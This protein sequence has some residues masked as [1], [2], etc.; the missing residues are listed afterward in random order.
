MN[1]LS[2]LHRRLLFP[3]AIGF[4]LF[5]A[6]IFGYLL[7]RVQERMIEQKQRETV[8]K[9]QLVLGLLDELNRR[10]EMGTLTLSQAQSIALDEIRGIRYGRDH[11]NYFWVLDYNCQLLI[12][13]YHRDLVSRSNVKDFVN[14]EGRYIFAEFVELAKSEGAGFIQ[15]RFPEYDESVSDLKTSYVAAF[16]G[17]E[18]V[19]GT[20]FF[21][22]E[23][24]RDIESFIIR[25]TTACGGIALVVLILY[26]YLYYQMY[27]IAHRSKRAEAEAEQF[28]RRFGMVFE[29]TH[30]LMGMISP[31]GQV[32]RINQTALRMIGLPEESVKNRLFWETPWWSYAPEVQEECRRAVERA[33]AGETVQFETVH[34]TVEGRKA[35]VLV[36]FTPLLNTEGAVECILAQGVDLTDL[37]QAE[38]QLR[39]QEARYR[40]LVENARSLILRLDA[41][42]RI[43]FINEFALELLG[44]PEGELLG[45]SPVETFILPTDEADRD[46]YTPFRKMLLAGEDYQGLVTLCVSVDG[47]KYWISWS[48]RALRDDED[49]LTG[50]NLLV[51]VDVT[52]QRLAYEERSQLVA[53]VETLEEVVLV[54]DTVGNVVYANPALER[55][56]GLEPSAW[57]GKPLTS[58]LEQLRAGQFIEQL[59]QVT[60]THRR[61]WQERVMLHHSEGQI[62][63]VEVTARLVRGRSH[64]WVY[65]LRDVTREV[66]EAER[67]RQSQKMEAMGTLA[68]GIAH[69]F[70]NILNAITGNAELLLDEPVITPSGRACVDEILTAS[71]RASD[72]VRQI[73]TYSRQKPGELKPLSIGPLVKEALKLVKISLPPEVTLH[74]DIAPNLP[75]VMGD[76]TQIH[77]VVL[78]LCTNAI[79]AMEETQGGL[80]GVSLSLARFENS[81]LIDRDQDIQTGTYVCL[82]ISDT[83]CGIPEHIRDRIFDPFFTTKPEGKGTGMG[84]AIVQGV[85]SS[86]GGIIRLFSEPSWGTTFRLYFPAL[87]SPK[88]QQTSSDKTAESEP[89][90]PRP[91]V[92]GSGEKIL[93]VDDDRAVL[94]AM[95]LQ[96]RKLG[97][98]P[99]AMPGPREALAAFEAD[100]QTY[101]MIITDSNM[102]GMSGITMMERIR[103]IRPD[104]PAILV[105]GLSTNQVDESALRAGIRRT[106]TKPIRMAH[107]EEAI[108][109]VLFISGSPRPEGYKTS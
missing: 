17:W 62:L 74:M 5:V 96:L 83:G 41:T 34:Y 63:D 14:E 45:R 7:P 8:D 27:R 75:P 78:N 51:G 3:L 91:P 40:L 79:H 60:A 93:V 107:L 73:L 24:R 76:I 109:E 80:L 20:G 28:F 59:R 16:G 86:H 56:T 42:G 44:Y 71:E 98:T 108:R 87:E 26:S 101:A 39:E 55:L 37:K 10:V 15:Y 102:P 100:P 25:M 57:T 67:Q 12:H 21:H 36:T 49:T 2:A 52:T 66:L 54:A 6:V 77:Q 104:V 61:D 9:V 19:I 4:I 72:L 22:R 11:K 85:M 89:P 47:R 70:N 32:L 29:Q 64:G 88:P 38:H 94:N 97:F 68:A 95:V 48:C 90:A 13:P 84:L 103:T 18:W 105:T 82:T 106:L 35:N 31:D 92:R 65:V 23:I 58:L 43:R 99:V 1:V 53:A 30:Q 46:Q 33:G 81:D 69:D 50:E